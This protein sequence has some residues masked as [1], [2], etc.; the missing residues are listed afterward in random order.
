[1]P[2][3][4][5]V[6][7]HA[8]A[9]TVS[10]L[11]V[12]GRWHQR[13]VGQNARGRPARGAAYASK[14][15]A[16]LGIEPTSEPISAH[17]DT[18]WDTAVARVLATLAK[19][20]VEIFGIEAGLRRMAQASLW[21]DVV[22]ADDLLGFVHSQR[23]LI[24]F[25][26]G[27]FADALADFS[28]AA[29][30]LDVAAGVDK[31]RLL[32]NRGA[33]HVE[34]GNLDA[35]RVDL[36]MSVELARQLVEPGFE[37]IATHNLGC[38]E[39]FA[40]D[41]PLALRIIDDGIAMDRDTQIGIA[42]LDRSRV[43]LAAGLRSEADESLA[44]AAKQLSTDR[45]W[46]DVGEVELTRAESALLAG[47]SA[48][49]RR[50]AGRARDRFRRHGNDRWRR[51]A[52]LVLLQ[53]DLRAGRPPGRLI[54]PAS[55]LAAEFADDGF[56]LQARTA[57][58]IAAELNQRVGNDDGAARLATDAG[59][60]R[61][62][63][64]IAVRLH[65]RY[66]HA[67]L[68]VA[69]G[70]LSIGR[71]QIR[72][73]MAELS[74][75]QAQFGGIDLQTSSAVHGT[76]LAELD[77]SL[78]LR[79][80]T[81]GATFA[82]VERGRAVSR[83]LRQVQ[84]PRDAQTATLLAELRRT[85]EG[86]REKQADPG[87]AASIA[88]DRQRV[89]DLERQLRSRSWQI[90]GSG[91]ASTAAS[92]SEIRRMLSVLD[93]V[94]ACYF[95]S[96]GSLF[97]VLIKSARTTLHDLGPAEP[98]ATLIS[99]VRADLGALANVR[100]PA[101]ILA[102][103]QSSLARSLAGLDELLV[104]PLQL[105]DRRLVA[106]P[107]G[108]LSMMP[109][110]L[111]PSLRGRPVVVAPS[112]TSWLHASTARAP[113]ADR[114][115][116]SVFAGPGL[117]MSAR[118]AADV[119]ALWSGGKVYAGARASQRELRLELAA[120]DL[121]HVAA[122]GQH[123][124]QSPLFSSLRLADG[125]LFAYELDQSARMADHVVLSACELGQ[126]TVRPGDEALGLTSVLLHLGARSVVAGVTSVPDELCAEVM[127][128]YHGQLAAGVDSAQALATACLTSDGSPAPFVC[129]GSTWAAPVSA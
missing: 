103:V 123:Q 62:V 116:V 18:A 102:A 4:P 32:I 115:A 19:S 52:E 33:L 92:A 83:R 73:G 71:R 85:V 90:G 2:V 17:A 46:Q 94:L 127:V 66:V 9:L 86:I 76:R 1:M 77:V 124:T 31:C 122:H 39:F 40:G 27:R 88:A 81:P 113:R 10:A 61:A 11:A 23:A 67:L 119:G 22:G 42:L 44:T 13:A 70:N 65:T 63:D 69:Q 101:A 14:A 120:A 82:A 57:T 96:R 117:A 48:A 125:P 55:R 60:A 126:A 100:L 97:A 84:P 118:E 7:D 98:V 35:A 78:A 105:P 29:G 107:S 16:A 43:L 3:P 30:Y 114:P 95:E 41:L 110:G 8:A 47:D 111:L 6:P 5:T 75:Y 15:L 106:V 58:L 72:A 34:M 99:K 129:F 49:A 56:P 12:S 25:R 89:A 36:T 109:W 37:R 74:A 104:V 28:A 128:R 45:S 24:L 79:A 93:E 54:A 80:G 38:L 50:L 59:P 21:A 26:G 20:E 53:S 121:V 68:A 91:G 51:N 87:R 64:P 108:S 112:A